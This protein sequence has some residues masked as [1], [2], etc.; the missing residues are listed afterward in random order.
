MLRKLLL[1]SVFLMINSS[2]LMA[3]VA[4]NYGTGSG[5]F[6]YINAKTNP[7][8]DIPVPIG[9]QSFRACENGFWVLDTIG[10]KLVKV[11]F[12]GKILREITYAGPKEKILAEDFYVLNKED[13]SLDC[14]W[15]IDGYN[16]RLL[17]IMPDGKI[18]KTIENDKMIQPME[19]EIDSNGNFMISDYGMQKIF[20]LTKDGGHVSEIAYQWSGFVPGTQ[21]G[22]L[23]RLEFENQTQ[24]LSLIRQTYDNKILA[25]IPL[26]LSGHY[27]SHIW[28]VDEDTNEM[29]ITYKLKATEP[30]KKC[31]A[32]V[33]LDGKIKSQGV[34]TVPIA[35]T[36]KIV[37][38]S[39][40]KTWL[41]DADYGKA[42][43]GLLKI[44][45]MFKN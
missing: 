1:I 12:N 37:R 29:L 15:I 3:G 28:W 22:T 7:G 34:F 19:I 26:G 38:D 23:Y 36:R 25:S 5:Q 40:G 18:G 2:V 31:F 24:Q 17:Q 21:A 13:G 30:G 6:G 39:K 16:I 27:N 33:G 20:V 9:P 45:D 35:P 14:I 8:E 10:N 4:L 11:D 43:D 44:I 41:I 42:P 32:V